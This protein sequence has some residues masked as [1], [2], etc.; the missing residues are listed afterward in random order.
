MTVKGPYGRFKLATFFLS[1]MLLRAKHEL[2]SKAASKS[3]L[4]DHS[5][6]IKNNKAL[7]T[8]SKRHQQLQRGHHI[9]HAVALAQRSHD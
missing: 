6:D 3:V 8:V 1:L 4:L 7:D 2:T 9:A 5:L